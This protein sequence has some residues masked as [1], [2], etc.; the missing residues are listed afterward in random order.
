M[1][2]PVNTTGASTYTIASVMKDGSSPTSTTSDVTDMTFTADQDG[3]P[4]SPITISNRWIYTYGTSEAWCTDR[5]SGVYP[6]VR[7]VY[8][9]RMQ[10]QNYTF[11]G[12]PKDGLIQTTVGVDQFYLLGNPYPSSIS[13]LRFIGDNL[14]ATTGTLYFWEQYESAFNGENNGL[15]HNA[16]GY[17]GGYSTRNITTGIAANQYV[18]GDCSTGKWK[19]LHSS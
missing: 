14:D 15:G 19:F 1:G 4:T 2:T 17:V 6:T 3:S 12:T 16:N 18:L 7:W 10:E 13:A 9:K 11:V 5:S 8:C